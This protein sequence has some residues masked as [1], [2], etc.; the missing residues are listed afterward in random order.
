MATASPHARGQRKPDSQRIEV[1]GVSGTEQDDAGSGDGNPEEVERA[2]RGGERDTERPHELE[3]HGD[4][5]WDSVE[6]EV[7][8][9]V[10]RGEHEPEHD[11]QS[12]LGSRVAAQARTPDGEQHDGGDG[13][14]DERRTDCAELLEE[15]RGERC[16]ELHRGD[17]RED[18]GDRRDGAAWQGVS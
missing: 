10:H 14:A 8:A 11:R 3:G 4:S 15:R 5:Q 7:E 16:A 2:A 1:G 17:R 6:R 18:E 12:N 9:R 13:D